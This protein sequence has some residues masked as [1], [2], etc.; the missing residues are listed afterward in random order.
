GTDWYNYFT[1]ERLSAGKT[2]W[3]GDI[4]T[5]PL[6]IKAGTILPQAPVTQWAD[7]TQWENM[8]IVVY[9]SADSDFTLYED[10]GDNYNYEQGKYSTIALHWNDKAGTLSISKRSGS[11]E[12]MLQNRTFN[13]RVVGGRTATVSYNGKAQTLKKMK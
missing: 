11:F 12:G 1:D 5:F 3:Q 10:E 2:Q 13:I 8:D 4:R 6:Y 7:M 9:P